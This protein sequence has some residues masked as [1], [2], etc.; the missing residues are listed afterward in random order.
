MKPL[1]L[2]LTHPTYKHTHPDHSASKSTAIQEE[3]HT[4]LAV[5]AIHQVLQIF[6][7]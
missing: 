4:A 6:G 1:K 5:S 3:A 2:N 7:N